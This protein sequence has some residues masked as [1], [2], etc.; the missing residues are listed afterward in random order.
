MERKRERLGAVQRMRRT[1]LSAFGPSAL[2]KSFQGD[3]SFSTSFYPPRDLFSLRNKVP[4]SGD[5]EASP[6][7]ASVYHQV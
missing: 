4:S 2:S 3:Y 1:R 7:Y 6:Q 5:Y